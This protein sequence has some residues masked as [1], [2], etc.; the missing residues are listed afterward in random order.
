M[1]DL[2]KNWTSIKSR[3]KRHKHLL[4][5]SDFDGTLSMI[6]KQPELARLDKEIKSYLELIKDLPNVYIGVISGRPLKEIKYLVGIKDIFYAGNHGFE[7]EY[8]DERNKRQLFVYAEAKKSIPYLKIIALSLKKNFKDIKG[9]LIENK[10]FTLSLHYRMVKDEDLPKLK[11]RFLSIIKP[12]VEKKKVKVTFGKKVI[13]IRPP[14]D[15]NKSDILL[16]IKSL[17]RKRGLITFY[18]G[19]DQTDE[20]V[21]KVLKDNDVSIFV[22]KNGSSSAA[23]RIKKPKEVLNFLKDLYKFKA[24]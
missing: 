5:L 10:I 24:N 8:P 15:W 4:L 6:V 2:F 12:S 1:K 3:I 19:D 21:F 9:V 14:F 16:K 22:G 13:E 20:C 17:V 18:L 23:Y 11:R 7:F